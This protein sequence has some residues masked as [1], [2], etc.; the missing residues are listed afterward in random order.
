MS[1]EGGGHISLV[2]SLARGELGVTVRVGKDSGVE[3]SRA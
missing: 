3:V 1:S 2:M